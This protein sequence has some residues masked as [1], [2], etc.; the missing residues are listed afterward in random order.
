MGG[1]VRHEKSVI[2]VFIEN[3]FDPNTVSLEKMG[4]LTAMG[5]PKSCFRKRVLASFSNWVNPV[6]STVP[7]TSTSGVVMNVLS[8]HFGLFSCHVLRSENRGIA[9]DSP[10]IRISSFRWKARATVR[11]PDDPWI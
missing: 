10:K 11:S 1:W 8:L 5:K 3:S 7:V 4:K 6:P 2:F 9:N